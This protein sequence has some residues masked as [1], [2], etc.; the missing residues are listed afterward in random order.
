MFEFI[1][2]HQRLMQFFL[3]I[4]LG[5]LF[6]IGGMQMGRFGG[7][8]DD[9]VAKVGDKAITQ[10]ELE[11]ALRE[12]GPNAANQ[13]GVRQQ[14]LDKL[15]AEQAMMVEA[16]HDHSFPASA[17]IQAFV[18]K[19]FPELADPKLSKEERAQRYT[20]LAAAQGMSVAGLESQVAR[21]LVVERTLGAV[22]SSSFAPKSL[23]AHLAEAIAQEREVQQIA[24]K[25]ADY[26][27][28]IKPTDEQLK[29][30]YNKNLAQYQ[31]PEQAK[32]EYVVLSAD[33]LAQQI[34]VSDADANAF[35]EQNKKRYVVD[36]QWRASHILIN[37][38]KSASDEVKSAAK[39]KAE[40]LLA[41][42]RKNPGEFA[43]LAKENSDDPGSAER[44]G[45]LDFFGKGMMV[46]PFEDA[47]SKMKV[48]EISDVVQSDYGYHIIMLTGIKPAQTKSLDE[49]KS[50][51]VAEL[52]KQR[53]GKLYSEL[54]ETF[55][56]TVYEQADSLQPVI[57]KLA[58]KAKLKI[59]TAV[60]VA[61]K[62]DPNVAPSV[63][64]NNPKFLTA[65]FAD[66]SIK[67]KHNTEAQEVA[68]GVMISGRVSEYKPAAQKSL[69][70]VQASVREAV[71]Q[72][73]AR[74]MAQK[75]EEA[76]LAALKAKDDSTGFGAVQTVSRPK[77]AGLSPAVLQ[78]VMKADASALPA[79]VGV[80]EPGVGYSVYRINKVSQPAAQD[81]GLSSAVQQQ[82]GTA[83]AQ[84]ETLTYLEALKQKAKVKILRPDFV[85][86]PPG[87]DGD[88]AD[89]K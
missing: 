76:K 67:G 16:K 34:N 23:A 64:Y 75:A 73:E 87:K 77:P 49:V 71:T 10:Q 13:P 30:Y 41:E 62:P 68:P 35:Y 9:V 32:I 46:K 81:P 38:K 14:L 74:K 27:S 43:K 42:V 69:D 54:R 18:L 56:N 88:G 57:D 59:E 89:G 37:A 21:M 22:Q 44:G 47:V 86:P 85:N 15:I 70:E 65:L 8:S 36:E 24:F 40:K 78:A 58:D 5:P 25:T 72:E 2:T 28:Q 11:Y 6:V 20:A 33:S 55:T 63:A 39:A 31:V 1:R 3:L 29:A 17:D 19:T 83:L 60:N 82:L 26:T 50:D 4:F 79:F 66:D 12:Q 45:D 80:D 52:K 53:A 48:N 84:Q 61:R 51:I 7:G